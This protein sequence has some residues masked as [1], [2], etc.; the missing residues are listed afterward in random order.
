MSSATRQGCRR[1]ECGCWVP[2]TGRPTRVS[3]IGTASRARARCAGDPLPCSQ[4]NP[5]TDATGSRRSDPERQEGG[6]QLS[7]E[8]T[9]PAA[10]DALPADDLLPGDDPAPAEDSTPAG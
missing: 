2:P 9:P 6:R 7:T 1:P 4:R 10:D 8:P 3:N 5:R